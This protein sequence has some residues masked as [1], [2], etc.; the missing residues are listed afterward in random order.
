M[1]ESSSAITTHELL[2]PVVPLGSAPSEAL[3]I[4]IHITMVYSEVYAAV[5]ASLTFPF[6]SR[7]VPV[8]AATCSPV[9]PKRFAVPFSAAELSISVRMYAFASLITLSAFAS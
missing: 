4:P 8:L 5:H 1:A 3:S 6:E 2:P 7:F 9:S